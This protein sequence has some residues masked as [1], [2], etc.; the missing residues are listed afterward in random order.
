MPS[1]IGDLI[2]FLKWWSLI[3]VWSVGFD[4]R[5][6]VIESQLT[7]IS[8]RISTIDHRSPFP[9]LEGRERERETAVGNNADG[10]ED[11][12]RIGSLR[13]GNNVEI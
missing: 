3:L 9:S 11:P 6:G 13:E 5:P 7:E 12:A 1:L 2:I 8:D 10:E 4:H